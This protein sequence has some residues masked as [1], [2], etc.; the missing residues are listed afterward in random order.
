MTH[1]N[2]FKSLNTII[3][4]NLNLMHNSVGIERRPRLG[5]KTW[6]TGAQFLVRTDVRTEKIEGKETNKENNVFLKIFF[7][8]TPFFALECRFPVNQSD[9]LNDIFG[10]KTGQCRRTDNKLDV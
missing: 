7:S 1:E 3:I 8:K 9:S 5:E 10:E 6:G 2:S 4:N